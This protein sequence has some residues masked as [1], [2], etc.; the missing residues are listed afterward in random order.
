MTFSWSG[1]GHNVVEVAGRQELEDCRGFSGQDLVP[2][3]GP[4]VWQ[5]LAH[6]EADATGVESGFN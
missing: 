4:H 1:S 6:L 3:S 5:V 2:T